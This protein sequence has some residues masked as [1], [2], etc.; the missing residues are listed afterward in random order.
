MT[1]VILEKAHKWYKDFMD[2]PQRKVNFEEGN[3]M[4]LN[5]KKFRLPEGLSHKFLS[6]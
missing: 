6:P 2:K 1:K 4:W 3:E 5:I